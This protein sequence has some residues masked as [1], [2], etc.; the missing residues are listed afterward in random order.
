MD[1]VKVHI[2]SA[3]GTGGREKSYLVGTLG[4]V[5]LQSTVVLLKFSTPCALIGI[6]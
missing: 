6:S 4:A 5:V 1:I 3:E 2:P